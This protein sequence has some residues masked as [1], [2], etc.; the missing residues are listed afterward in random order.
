MKAVQ[1]CS[2]E[3]TT[4]G[5]EAAPNDH[6]DEEKSGKNG[7]IGPTDSSRRSF[8]GKVGGATAVALAAGIPLEPVFEGKHGEAEASVIHYRSNRRTINSWQYRRDTAQAEKIDVGELP[9]NGDL[10]RFT[11]YSG[12]WSK[13][14]QHS[15]L[16]IPNPTSYQSLLY[17]LQT[18]RFVDF[19]NVLVGN[20]G[21][22]N[23]TA[24]LNGPQG[25]L[26]F[27]LEGL[28]SHA[29]VI[30]PAPSVASGQT[31]A[32]QVEHYWAALMR[33]VPFT[34]YS[35][36]SQAA[37]ACA[38][39][40]NLLYIRSQQ[41]IEYP[42]PITP[43]NLFRG[44]IVPGDG[45]LQ[46]PYV[47]QFMMQPTFFGVQPLTQQCQRYLSVSQGGGDFMTSPSEYLAVQNGAVPNARLAFDPSYC[48]VRMGRDLAAYTRVDV[49]YQAYQV[50]FLVL[51]GIGAPA[52]PGNP[53]RGSQTEHGFGTL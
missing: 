16:G 37:Q 52:N 4:V 45:N 9:D 29:T 32:E 23:A 11:D 28:D 53:Y 42:Y 47:S 43:Q 24:T 36:S 15:V 17:A 41:N 39:L 49:L 13:C 1:G 5:G 25:A 19:G 3:A 18:G 31:A 35:T 46:G 38:D 14:L 8:L 21:G 33:D 2:E 40:N 51:A 7:P 27:D 26:A 50:A 34:D 22:T 6:N 48:F 30:P 20:P 10:Q 44:Q 12:N